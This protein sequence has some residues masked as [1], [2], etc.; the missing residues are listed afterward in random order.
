VGVI[1]LSLGIA[2]LSGCAPSQASV[3]AEVPLSG[4]L[5][6][7]DWEALTTA[8]VTSDVENSEYYVDVTLAYAGDGSD[9]R[10]PMLSVTVTTPTGTMQCDT[11]RS[12][13]WSSFDPGSMMTL[14]LWCD[15]VLT[16]NEVDEIRSVNL[17]G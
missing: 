5:N 4:A 15:G 2:G 1:A 10:T 13:L 14:T 12:Y 7:D 8:T 16:P 17:R 3:S 6:G 11:S 9:N